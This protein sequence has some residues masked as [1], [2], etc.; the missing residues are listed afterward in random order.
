M[1]GNVSEW[2]DNCEQDGTD[3]SRDSCY[4]RGGNV[5]FGPYDCYELELDER[6]HVDND[7]E[8]GG[9]CCAD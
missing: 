7:C 8:T 2:E 3:R 9:R 4:H 6:S 1:L 5:R